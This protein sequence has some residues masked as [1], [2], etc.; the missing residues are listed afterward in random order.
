MTLS[1]VRIIACSDVPQRC[2]LIAM[3]FRPPSSQS[4]QWI[5]CVLYRCRWAPSSFVILYVDSGQTLSRIQIVCVCHATTATTKMPLNDKETDKSDR[6][7]I[8]VLGVCLGNSARDSRLHQSLPNV[9]AFFPGSLSI[10][11]AV[12]RVFTK[13]VHL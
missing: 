3:T 5:M 9:S 1:V 12:I 10:S 13:S 4:V 7:L 8:Q 2:P 6:F 11:G